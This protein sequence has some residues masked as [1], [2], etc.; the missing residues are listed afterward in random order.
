MVSSVASAR[1]IEPETKPTFLEK[2]TPEKIHSLTSLR[3]FACFFMVWYHAHAHFFGTS[4]QL[5]H[6][7][8]EPLLAF[9]FSLSGFVLTHNY[10]TL[11]G[12]RETF[13]FY[14]F[15]YSRLLPLHVLIAV[16]FVSLLPGLFRPTGTAF[17]S[18]LLLVHAWIPSSQYF[19]SYNSPS[20]SNSTEIFFYLCFPLL[21]ILMRKAWYLTPL[22]GVIAAVAAIAFCTINNVPHMSANSTCVVGLAFVHPI[23]RLFEFS[24][25]MVAATLFHTRLKPLNLNPIAATALELAGLGWIMLSGY[26]SS[27][28]RHHLMPLIGDAGSLWI[29]SAAVPV[30]G[31]ALLIAALATERGMLGRILNWRLLVILG[32]ASFAMYML[33]SL[34]L[35][36]A[37][38]NFPQSLSMNSYLLF[39]ATLIVGGHFLTNFID[40]EL[41]R[42]FLKAGFKI[43]DRFMP[44]KETSKKPSSSKSA[45]SRL[46]HLALLAAE[47]TLFAFLCWNFLPAL[48]RLDAATATAAAAVCSVKDVAFGSYLQCRGASAESTGDGVKARMI[49]ESLVTSKAD[50]FVKATAIDTTGHEI[51]CK[52]YCVSPRKEIAA[53]GTMWQDEVTI[54]LPSGSNVAAMSILVIRKHK[55]L[56]AATQNSVMTIPVQRV[57]STKE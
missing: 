38:V 12:K 5:N 25:G 54:A 40:P 49:W 35:T 7:M 3:F 46:P 56:A 28:I 33:H 41:R 8:F 31:C 34:L 6:D 27:A 57:A 13:N 45:K 20:W 52:T 17:L 36:Y 29:Q 11:S 42:M 55:Q 47:G 15:R 24:M 14:L 50:Y 2:H 22:P 1:A 16:L 53:K 10:P 4:V 39:W 37:S 9:F 51:G 23:A 21:L 18:N 48:N 43:L 32:E 30:G 26:Y 44:A 19:F